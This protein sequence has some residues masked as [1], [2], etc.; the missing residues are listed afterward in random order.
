MICVFH[1]RLSL[2]GEVYTSYY[3]HIGVKKKKK[4]EK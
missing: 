4:K 2:I 1:I 3:L